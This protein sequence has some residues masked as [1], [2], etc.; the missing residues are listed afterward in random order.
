MFKTAEA[1]RE[2]LGE[3][4]GWI[5]D[6][7]WLVN[8]AVDSVLGP[9]GSFA[10]FD[11][12]Q[13]EDFLQTVLPV[14]FHVKSV[15]E[16]EIRNAVAPIKEKKLCFA[17]DLEKEVSNTGREKSGQIIFQALIDLE[18]ITRPANRYQ[19]FVGNLLKDKYELEN[20]FDLIR[21]V[22]DNEVFLWR[23][24]EAIFLGDGPYSFSGEPRFAGLFADLERS[25]QA[26]FDAVYIR[27]DTPQKAML[28]QDVS[29]IIFESIIQSDK[30]DM[31]NTRLG[32]H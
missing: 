24:L 12:E 11:L 6:V 19:Y 27:Q 20:E 25:F 17:S 14:I 18:H 9:A 28:M 21:R 31:Q 8:Y 22:L 4:L 5:S 1:A 32:D 29:R 26:A 3:A 13:S 30:L 2:A 7:E 16:N 15:E 10:C 23:Y